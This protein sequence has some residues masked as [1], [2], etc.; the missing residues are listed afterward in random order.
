MTGVV[1]HNI[2]G[3]GNTQPLHAGHTNGNNGEQVISHISEDR[4]QV[5]LS[6]ENSLAFEGTFDQNESFWIKLGRKLLNAGRVVLRIIRKFNPFSYL[7]DFIEWIRYKDDVKNAKNRNGA[8]TNEELAEYHRSLMY[9]PNNPN[10]N[11]LFRVHLSRKPGPKPLVIL[12]LGNT[13]TTC[14]HEFPTGVLNLYN[15]LVREGDVDVIVF[16]VGC[17][18]SQLQFRYGLTNDASLHP[19]VVLEHTS[20]IIEDIINARGI[21]AGRDRPSRVLTCGFSWGGGTAHEIL[22]NRWDEIG[23]G[24]PVTASAY[25]D[26]IS[27]AGGIHDLGEPITTRP[28]ISQSH[29]NTYQN[30]SIFL[31][32]SPMNQFRDGDESHYIPGRTHD[33]IEDADSDAIRIVYN[34]FRRNIGP[35]LAPTPVADSNTPVLPCEIIVDGYKIAGR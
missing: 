18:T 22:Q 7:L 24:V 35:T 29:C 19:R 5:I 33:V 9:N 31:N 23:Q 27:Y 6:E 28:H 25:I 21:F 15:R 1:T 20:N 14:D 32:G 8:R 2:T 30:N 13:Q 12:F 17:A 3:V 34:F 10:P 16:R 4:D 26:G 11:S